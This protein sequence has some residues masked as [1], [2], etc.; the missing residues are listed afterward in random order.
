MKSAREWCLECDL[1]TF[2][3]E[4]DWVRSIQADALE[5]A[6]TLVLRFNPGFIRADSLDQRLALVETIFN[7]L[8]RLAKKTKVAK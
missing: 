2:E 4:V 8:K 1:A 6:A 7:H 3:D 5:H